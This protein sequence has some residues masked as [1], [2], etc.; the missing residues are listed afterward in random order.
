MQRGP[1]LYRAVQQGVAL[2]RRSDSHA[3]EPV[4]PPTIQ[5]AFDPDLVDHGVKNSCNAP[6][7]SKP[8]RLSM[9]TDFV[10]PRHIRGSDF[11]L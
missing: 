9:R 1:I 8:C 6:R 4:R 11:L 5:K 3:A 2:F 10:L 7:V